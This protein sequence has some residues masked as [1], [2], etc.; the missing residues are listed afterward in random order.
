MSLEETQ[1]M[2]LLLR[3]Q[4]G[5][6]A[7]WLKP[8]YLGPV[9]RVPVWALLQGLLPQSVIYKGSNPGL[10]NRGCISFGHCGALLC[11]YQPVK[12][13]R[14]GFGFSS[15]RGLCVVHAGSKQRVCCAT[16]CVSQ[17]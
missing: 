2:N 9:S 5:Y 15:M 12:S 17:H 4:E 10:L 7:A 14:E 8:G 13:W 3:W 16:L 1:R 11:F 6:N